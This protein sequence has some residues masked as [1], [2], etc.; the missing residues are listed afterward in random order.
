ME[1]G[2]DGSQISHQLSDSWRT[3][4]VALPAVPTQVTSGLR[5]FFRLRDSW[6]LT[7]PEPLMTGP[8]LC[9]PELM[10]LALVEL[11]AFSQML[12]IPCPATAYPSHLS[13]DLSAV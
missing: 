13:L 9:L 10:V 2:A 7:P 1:E 3:M 4:P 12:Q 5:W 11:P 6:T 8:S